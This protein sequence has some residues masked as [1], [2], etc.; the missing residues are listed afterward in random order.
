VAQA[1]AEPLRV[2]GVAGPHLEAVHD[3]LGKVGLAENLLQRYPRDLSGGERQRVALARALVPGP[4]L[5]IAD[6]IVSMLDS[7]SK[8]GIL[9]LLAA[10]RDKTGLSVLFISHDVGVAA[11]ICDRI[12]VLYRGRIVEAGPTRR[13]LTRPDHPHTARLI[14]AVPK[15]L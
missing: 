13:I 9:S 3:A 6:E 14:A 4:R 11:H 2:R 7:T 10:L 12:A 15:L 8:V 1:V 5:V